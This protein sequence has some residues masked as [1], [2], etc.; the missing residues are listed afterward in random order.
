[1]ASSKSS[2]ESARK[3]LAREI[4]ASRF[5]I[6]NPD[7]NI[8][9]HLDEIGEQIALRD[10][11]NGPIA[12]AVFIN[13]PFLWIPIDHTELDD[14]Q[15]V[16]DLGKKVLAHLTLKTVVAPSIELFAPTG[17][18]KKSSSKKGSKKAGK[19]GGA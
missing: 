11:Y 10:F 15:T 13:T 2:S 18:S 16:R 7:L 3:A 19:K 14:V 1:M 4:V 5:P 12:Q 17:G 9:Q 8:R 6:V